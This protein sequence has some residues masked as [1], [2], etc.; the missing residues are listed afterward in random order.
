MLFNSLNFLIFFPIVLFIYFLSPF[1]FR[2]FILL[3]ASCIFYMFFVPVYILILGFTIVIDYIAGI[4]IESA[5]GKR[6]KLYLIMS[7]VS[8]IG[9][10]AVFKYYNF[11]IGNVNGLMTLSGGDFQFTFLKIIL[12]IGLSFHTFQAMSY[13]LEVY[14]GNQKAER[15]FGI[16]S[17][18][19]MFFPQLVAGPIERPQNMLHQFHTKH[20]FDFD[21]VMS[22][23]NLMFWG[24]FKKMVIADRL[25]F[26]IDPVFANP[27]KY[28]GLPI[29]ISIVFF[30]FQIYC[31]FSGYSDIAIGAAR[32]MGFR[33]M[34]NF[35]QPFTATSVTEFWR[36][37]HISLYSWFNDYLF[38]P[39]LVSKRNWGKY[40]IYYALF[41]TF[42]LSGLWH[43]AAWT[44]I[45]WGCLHAVALI[46]EVIT[47]G[48]RKSLSKKIPT[49]IYSMVSRLFVFCFLCF[50][51][52]FFRASSIKNA[53]AFIKGIGGLFNPQANKGLTNIDHYMMLWPQEI[54]YSSIGTLNFFVGIGGIA[55]LIIVE[56]FLRKQLVNHLGL[57]RLVYDLKPAF[58]AVALMVFILFAIFTN[59]KQFIYFQF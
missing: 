23:L 49:Y 15:H 30:A 17:L 46:Y 27:E 33:L 41:I 34:I 18:Y 2:W 52:I 58:Y 42:F 8:N 48:I 19:V 16:Y 37:W 25:T 45:I 55:I 6:K 39:I 54:A 57:S 9:I 22:G 26:F 10:L 24:F 11:F 44:Y 35:N 14:R 21:L 1:R 20:K 47:K 28:S 59:G 29:L 53:F 12:P 3:A 31:D 56:Y 50:A 43:G 32:I 36:K 38:T 40:A 7:L 5:E 13:T 4:L 51:W